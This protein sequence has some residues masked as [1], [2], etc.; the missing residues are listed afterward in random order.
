MT[1]IK[2]FERQ[3]G[4]LLQPDIATHAG[5]RTGQWSLKLL[6]QDT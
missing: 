1:D 2:L 3:I 5:S 6:L 4:I